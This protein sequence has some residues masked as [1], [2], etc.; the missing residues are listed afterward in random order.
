MIDNAIG[1]KH[2]ILYL[3][4]NKRIVDEANESGLFSSPTIIR[5]L[6]AQGHRIWQQTVSS[7]IVLNPRKIADLLRDLITKLP[8]AEQGPI[9]EDYHFILNSIARAKALGHVPEGKFP[10][11][12]RLITP[13]RFFNSLEEEPSEETREII[14]DILSLSIKASFAG[15]IDYNDQIYMPALFGGTFPRFPLILIDEAQDLSPVNHAML[16]KL[17]KAR[18]IAVGDPWQ[19]IYGFRGAVQGGMSELKSK[20]NMK[21]ADLS[22]S[23]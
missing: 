15:N 13:K 10:T 11:A 22:V 6:N 12:K 16:E 5:T 17:A 9:W 18:L 14:D 21:E 4:F 8:R 7:R 23:F 1:G 3:A 2:P 19:S 20:F